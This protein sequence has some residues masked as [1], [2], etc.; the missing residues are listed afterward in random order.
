MTRRKQVTTMRRLALLALPLL[1]AACA[2][3]QAG[4]GTAPAVGYGAPAPAAVDAAKSAGG[5]A[6]NPA[7]NQGIPN[8]VAFNV[9][10]NLILT[11][12]VSM[13][14][15][16]PWATSEKAQLIV[17]TLGGDVL[18]LNESG[19]AENRTAS[20]TARVPSSN[21]S[22]AL[23]QFRALEGEVV[24]STV[25]GQD[26]TDQF[27]DLQARLA[28]K[29]SEEQRYLALIARANT[30]D[31]IIK[32]DQSLS[33]VRTQIEQLTGQI[34]AIKS[35]T[36]FST[37]VLSVTPIPAVVPPVEEPGKA[38]DPAKTFAR[39]LATLGAML[40]VFADFAIWIMVFGA[41]PLIVLGVGLVATRTRRPAAPT[42]P[43]A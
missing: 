4:S 38:W 22:E 30:I 36:D 35:R 1:L 34:K 24:T 10:R 9:D 41:I 28:A 5:T 43:T 15:K 18:T 42:V 26:V 27:V 21:F 12:N 33:N 7:P 31:E 29:Q 19:S 20:L 17:A 39:A 40:R 6:G 32:V 23:R 37:L 13:R 14:S 16:D 25:T 3:S 8:P 2:G 11:A